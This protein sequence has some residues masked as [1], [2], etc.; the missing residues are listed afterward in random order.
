MGEYPQPIGRELS[1][2]QDQLIAGDVHRAPTAQGNIAMAK[3]MRSEVM[4][5]EA[6][7]FE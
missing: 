5:D 1:R 7:G 6:K 3:A 4:A 2:C